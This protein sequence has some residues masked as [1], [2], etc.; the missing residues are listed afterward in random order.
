M[1]QV[2]CVIEH[3]CECTGTCI[4]RVYE[5]K[6]LLEIAMKQR[7]GLNGKIVIL[8]SIPEGKIPFSFNFK[9]AFS[10]MAGNAT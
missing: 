9:R 2:I 5:L 3:M 1:G 8:F 6:N 7:K 4:F 10:L